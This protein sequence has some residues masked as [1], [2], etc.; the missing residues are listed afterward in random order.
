MRFLSLPLH[1]SLAALAA[2]LASSCAQ[3][4][5]DQA[6]GKP[7]SETP[8]F[9]D[10]RE[11]RPLV[12][13]TI[14]QGRLPDPY[15]DEGR[16]G[17]GFSGK[18]PFPVTRA[19][20]ERGRQRYEIYCAVCHDRTGEGR[21]M[22][23]QRG[24]PQPPSLLSERLRRA[25]AGVFVATMANGIGKMFPY[26]DR[27]P[28]DDRWA[29]AAYIRALQLRDRV[30]VARLTADERRRLGAERTEGSGLTPHSTG[31]KP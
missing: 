8:V 16:D 12:E 4:M 14:A 24:F 26:G 18:F 7:L 25:P 30:P 2:L 19:V 6:K 22:I 3:R 10:R 31:G 15:L 13:G 11:A 17:K 1:I 20:L 28:R 21:G 27:V 5:D 9:A 29:I 23:V